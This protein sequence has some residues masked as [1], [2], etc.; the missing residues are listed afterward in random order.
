MNSIKIFLTISLLVTVIM[1]DDIASSSGT[2]STE[3]PYIT[4]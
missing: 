4:N 1:A 3:K 2:N